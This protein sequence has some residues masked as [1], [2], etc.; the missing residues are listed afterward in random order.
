MVPDSLP[1]FLKSRA[2][3]SLRYLLRE[4]R[5]VGPSDALRGRRSDWPV[6]PWG[7]G[8]DGSIAGIVYHVAAWKHLSLSL[9]S[10]GGQALPRA[11]FDAS[12]APAADDWPAL[13]DWLAAIGAEWN[14]ALS[15]LSED[16]FR[17]P[18]EWEGGKPLSV[19]DFAYEMIQ[20]DVQHAAQIEYLRQL[21]TIVL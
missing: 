9:L 19:A 3:R 10:P 7:I 11:A 8:Q 14:A 17:S 15:A 16:E 6:Q 1:A 12:A 21:Y 20:H 5:A 13:L 4:A 18:R 2:E